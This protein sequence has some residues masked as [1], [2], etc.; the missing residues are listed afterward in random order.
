MAMAM[1]LNIPK[2]VE[3][4]ADKLI[5]PVNNY[6]VYHPAD[7]LTSG[8]TVM[9]VGGP[10]A[11]TDYHINE[12][13][14]F[15]YQHKGSMLLKTVDT[16]VT[17][18]RF[19]DIPIHEN[20]IFLLPGN[21]P[22]NPVRFADTIGVVLELPRPADSKDRLRWYCKGCKEILHEAAFHCDDLGTQVKEG[23][24]AFEASIKDR[25]CKK[26]GTVNQ[27]KPGPGDVEQPPRFPPE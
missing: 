27:S 7:P 3:K 26:C 22:H 24:L 11:R 15:F 1:P 10:N 9:V 4:N 17:P 21:V 16:T 12:T 2:W 18:H 8:L 19:V 14:E 6:C 25:T 13:P 23:V 5:P 20:S